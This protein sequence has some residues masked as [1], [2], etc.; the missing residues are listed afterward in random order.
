MPLVFQHAAIVKEYRDSDSKYYN[1]YLNNELADLM[2]NGVLCFP[3][4]K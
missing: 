3:Y 2:P 1:E 4:P